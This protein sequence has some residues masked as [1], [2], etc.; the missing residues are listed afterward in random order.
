MYRDFA[1]TQ[2]EPVGLQHVF[3]F[4]R[5]HILSHGHLHLLCCSLQFCIVF[6]C[7]FSH[8]FIFWNSPQKTSVVWRISLD[9]FNR[10]IINESKFLME[11]PRWTGCAHVA[12]P[13]SQVILRWP[14]LNHM[15]A[16]QWTPI[17]WH[18]ISL[19]VH[20]LPFRHKSAPRLL[21]SQVHYNLQHS[22]SSLH[23]S[24]SRCHYPSAPLPYR[25]KSDQPVFSPSRFVS[26]RSWPNSTN[27]IAL[28]LCTTVSLS[29]K[30][31]K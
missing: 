6:S 14:F 9:E 31:N 16:Q 28:A 2:F 12:S 27:L 10:L 25:F 24:H 21:H 18:F 26:S 19:C 13:A 7:F 23:Q 5:Y 29:F 30:M 15:I 1:P 4:S 3:L 17:T 11:R 22:A 8:D 20:S